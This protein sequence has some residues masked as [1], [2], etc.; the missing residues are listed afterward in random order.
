VT[1][2]IGLRL[3]ELEGVVAHELSHVKRYDPLVSTVAVTALL[4]Q[5]AAVSTRAA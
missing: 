1:D 5:S 4:P 2:E 3:G